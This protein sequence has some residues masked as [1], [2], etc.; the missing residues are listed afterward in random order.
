M[1]STSVEELSYTTVAKAAE[2]HRKPAERTASDVIRWALALVIVPEG[3]FRFRFLLIPIRA[4]FQIKPM[5]LYG[6]GCFKSR[7]FKMFSGDQFLKVRKPDFALPGAALDNARRID[8]PQNQNVRI[9]YF[10]HTKPFEWL[11]ATLHSSFPDYQRNQEGRSPSCA[12]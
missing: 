7:D 5:R 3:L 10:L 1:R 11:P 6:F 2:E 12:I 4:S 8:F 9:I